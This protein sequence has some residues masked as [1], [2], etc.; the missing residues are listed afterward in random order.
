MVAYRPRYC[1]KY[2]FVMDSACIFEND[3]IGV[4]IASVIETSSTK[5]TQRTSKNPDEHGG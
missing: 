5:K 3:E 4:K 2:L 1:L